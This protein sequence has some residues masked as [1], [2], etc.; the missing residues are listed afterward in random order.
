MNCAQNLEMSA[1][2]FPERP[3]IREAG[4]ETT[5]A[6]LN[7]QANR[8]A[9]GLIEMGIKPGEHVA[10]CALNPV[11]WIVFYFSVLKAGAVAVT[12]SGLLTGDELVNLV[13]HSKP[14]FIFTA[15]NKLKELEKLK[16]AG[17]LEKIICS[18][19]D[20][21]LQ[22]LMGLGSGPF[23]AIDRDRADASEQ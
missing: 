2:F 4:S 3:A 21:D 6:Q 17:G 13:N 9:T 16:I 1:F 18:G 15:E 19:G 11:D 7:D 8:V 14:R 20:L 12:L 10:L 23:K 5:Y 22:H